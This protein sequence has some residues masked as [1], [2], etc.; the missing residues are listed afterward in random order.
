V[1]QEKSSVK[2]S[3]GLNV[4]YRLSLPQ[5]GVDPH[6]IVF[7]WT[8]YDGHDELDYIRQMEKRLN[9]GG[10]ATC[11]TTFSGSGP[12]AEVPLEQLTYENALDDACAVYSNVTD[13]GDIDISRIGF[14]GNSLGANVSTHFAAQKHNPKISALALMAVVPSPR[15]AFWQLEALKHC[16]DFLTFV[17]LEEQ[18]NKFFE[19]V[20]VKRSID[21]VLS[22][23]REGHRFSIS[24]D[25]MRQ[26]KEMSLKKR[27][28]PHI[29]VP[30][31]MMSG[32][33]DRL[34]SKK[35]LKKFRA[36][37][38]KSPRV[39]LEFLKAGH[40]FSSE[41]IDTIAGRTTEFFQDVFKI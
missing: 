12:K 39:E 37:F 40:Q 2:N 36:A 16:D 33:R 30:V 28:A 27:A 38:T 25:F 15:K 26:A 41:Q 5:G 6:A 29:D 21:K 10:M 18:R 13:R 9:K 7:L 20:G 22:F 24:Q 4:S 17:G 34:A 23:E 3:R 11:A 19:S 31:L 35:R 14:W 32:D 1:V 8:G